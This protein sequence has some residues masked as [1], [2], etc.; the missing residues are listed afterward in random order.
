MI[1][2]PLTSWGTISLSSKLNAPANIDVC[3]RSDKFLI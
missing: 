1:Q 3:E 2:V